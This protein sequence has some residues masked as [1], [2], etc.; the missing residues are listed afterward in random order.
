MFQKRMTLGE[1]AKWRGCFGRQSNS[2]AE[3]KT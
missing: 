3:D 1:N 2:F